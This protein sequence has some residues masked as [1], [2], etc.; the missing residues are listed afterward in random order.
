M[1]ADWDM[2][3]CLLLLVM[4]GPARADLT[5]VVNRTLLQHYFVV[6][7]GADERVTGWLTPGQRLCGVTGASGER[8]LVQVF[9]SPEGFEGCSRLVAPGQS[10]ALLRYV[11][12]DRCEWGSHHDA[13]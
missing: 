10:E 6:E 5:C 13:D 1:W 3:L 2:R 7:A 8:H 9:E 11:D 4:A 12:F